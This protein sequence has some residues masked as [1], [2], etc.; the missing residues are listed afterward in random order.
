VISQQMIVLKLQLLIMTLHSVSLTV[1]PSLVNAT[2]LF[3]SIKSSDVILV[4]LPVFDS[5]MLEI[6]YLL[7]FGLM[8]IT[9]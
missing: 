5:L 6:T 4:T 8:G 2:Q 1:P 7:L 9:F 3:I